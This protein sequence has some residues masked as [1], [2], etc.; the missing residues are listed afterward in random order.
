VGNQIDQEIAENAWP[1][2]SGSR[3]FRVENRCTGGPHLAIIQLM[4]TLKNIPIPFSIIII[5]LPGCVCVGTLCTAYGVQGELVWGVNC[6]PQLES[7]VSNLGQDEA[8]LNPLC[9]LKDLPEHLARD[10]AR[11]H[12]H[13]P[14]THSGH[15]SPRPLI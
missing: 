2:L 5:I 15:P 12:S 13:Q 11:V 3:L 6:L 10:H 7:Q 9:H 8:F 4:S 14:V 1:C